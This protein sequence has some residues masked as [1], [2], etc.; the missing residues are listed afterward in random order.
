VSSLYEL[1]RGINAQRPEHSLFIAGTQL[2]L[3]ARIGGIFSGLVVAL[4]YVAA[5][6]RSRALRYP[7][8]NPAL[9]LI[10]FPVLMGLDG[11]N[12]LLFDLGSPYLYPPSN[13]LRFATGL[14]TGLSL[15]VFVVPSLSSVLW[16]E[17]EP[18]AAVESIVD[19]LGPVGL[20]AL[21]WVLIVSDLA[22]LLA[23]AA[24]LFLL[25]AV[26][27]LDLASVYVIGAMRPWLALHWR[28][29]GAV[30]LVGGGLALVELL[31]LALLRPKIGGW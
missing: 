26:L 1:L 29:A 21:I 23:P 4:V 20:L 22:V 15:A 30:L 28:D 2:P 17:G 12:A 31:A 27:A 9:L 24:L 10:A 18:E 8:R 16:A 13:R 5:I 6:G 7:P 25:G 3:E 11:I 19:V 14:L